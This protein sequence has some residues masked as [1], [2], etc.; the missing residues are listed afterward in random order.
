MNFL[1]END[2]QSVALYT[3]EQNV[4]S[5]ALLKRLGFEFGHHWKFMRK[6]LPQKA[7]D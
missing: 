6:I 4:A 5:V 1:F 2:M 7:R 3:G